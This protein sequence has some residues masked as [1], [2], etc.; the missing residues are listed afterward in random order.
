MSKV[1]TAKRQRALLHKRKIRR[2][3]VLLIIELLILVVLG[4]AAYAMSKF[5]KLNTHTL[6]KSKLEI[7]QD[8]GDFTN[9]ALFGLDSREVR[10]K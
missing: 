6:N 5:D 10:S 2:R 3:I 4:A 1:K 8:T 9:V 7:Y